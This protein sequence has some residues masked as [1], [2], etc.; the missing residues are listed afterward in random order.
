MHD[1]VKFAFKRATLIAVWR[2]QKQKLYEHTVEEERL[3]KRCGG[4]DHGDSM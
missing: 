1:M 2:K 4:L 3:G